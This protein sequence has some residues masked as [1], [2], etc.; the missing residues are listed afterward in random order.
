M[1]VYWPIV[2]IYF[3]NW[4][5]FFIKKS[6][7]ADNK[8]LSLC[9]RVSSFATSYVLI[10]V[11][12]GKRRVLS[13]TTSKLWAWPP[14]AA[15]CTHWWRCERSSGRSSW[16]WGECSVTD[17]VRV[18]SLHDRRPRSKLWTDSYCAA[19]QRCQQTT[20]SRAHSGT[21]TPCSSPSSTQPE[22]STTP[23]SCL[24]CTLQC[25]GQT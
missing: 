1:W 16:K 14:T 21:L 6:P 24:V 9:G 3:W 11:E 4:P 20:S 17:G 19:S 5:I 2:I 18:A 15:T 8:N 12:A 7:S 25:F 13:H 10:S 22:T 23:S